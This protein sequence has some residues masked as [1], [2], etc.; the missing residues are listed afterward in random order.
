MQTAG[1]IWSCAAISPGERQAA[2]SQT[3][4]KHRASIPAGDKPKGWH[5]PRYTPGDDRAGGE[6]STV[7]YLVSGG[8][9]FFH[10]LRPFAEFSTGLAWLVTTGVGRMADAGSV[11]LQ[12]RIVEEMAWVRAHPDMVLMSVS[13]PGWMYSPVTGDWYE[14]TVEDWG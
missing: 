13:N 11:M 10:R 5:S 9:S 14:C 3:Q 2:G 6:A 4:E 8:W 12:R 1:A 7:P